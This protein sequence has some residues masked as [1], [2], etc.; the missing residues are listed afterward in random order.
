MNGSVW[1]RVVNYPTQLMKEARSRKDRSP[2]KA[3]VIA[4]VAVAVAILTVAPVRA[5]NLATIRLDE[6]LIKA[7]RTGVELSPGV[8]PL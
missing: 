8:S 7:R 3:A 4:E 5:A 1:E 6:N 2:M